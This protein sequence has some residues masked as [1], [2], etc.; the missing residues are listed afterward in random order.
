MSRVLDHSPRASVQEEQLGEEFFLQ[1]VLL[2]LSHQEDIEAELED[3]VH[4]RQLVEHDSV[5]HSLDE[6]ETG[7]AADDQNKANVQASDAASTESLAERDRLF[8]RR[9]TLHLNRKGLFIHTTTHS[10]Y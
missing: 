9:C 2:H 8:L 10:T 6:G 4:V 3:E 5:G 7:E 1:P